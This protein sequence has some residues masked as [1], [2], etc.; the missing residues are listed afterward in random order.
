M[1]EAQLPPPV[2]PQVPPLPLPID[3]LAAVANLKASWSHAP[4]ILAAAD[5]L[6]A[7]ALA[8]NAHLAKKAMQH[9]PR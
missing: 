6:R 7:Y 8:H 9:D 3:A 2:A 1:T 4:D 5:M